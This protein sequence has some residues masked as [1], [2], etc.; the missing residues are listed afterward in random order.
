MKSSTA[1]FLT[2]LYIV[3]GG[4]MVTQVDPFGIVGVLL[5]LVLVVGSASYLIWANSQKE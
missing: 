1:V 4:W 3:V 5:G 2:L